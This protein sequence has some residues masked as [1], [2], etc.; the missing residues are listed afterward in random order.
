MKAIIFT[1]ADSDGLCS[2]ALALAANGDSP[3]FSRTPCPF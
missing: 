1:H 3:Y 2:G